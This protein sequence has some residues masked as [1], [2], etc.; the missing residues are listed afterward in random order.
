[1]LKSIKQIVSEI[2]EDKELN[3]HLNAP[4]GLTD[5]QVIF[6]S[7]VYYEEVCLRIQ[8]SPLTRE[9]EKYKQSV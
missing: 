2:V 9:L 8:N 7:E 4:K 1:M 6:F 5:R 3:P